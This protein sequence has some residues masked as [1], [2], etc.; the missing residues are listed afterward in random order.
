MASSKPRPKVRIVAKIRGFTDREFE[1][2]SGD[3]APWI[4][5]RKPGDNN[6]SEKVK[7]CFGDQPTRDVYEVDYC[8][9]QNE[10]SSIIFE[11]EIKPLIS[12]VFDGQNITIIAF[13]ARGSGK[14]YTIQGTEENQGLATLAIAELLSVAEEIEKSVAISIYEVFQDRVYDLID[15][16]HPEVQVLEAHGKIKLKGLYQG[17]VKSAP[18]FHTLYSTVCNSSQ[19]KPKM[20]AELP[21]RSHKGLIIYALSK[22][23][24]SDTKLLGKINFVDLA[25]YEDI[26]RKSSEGL[27][28]AESSKIN[29]SL[30]AL[31]NVVYALNANETHVPYRESKLTRMLQDSFGGTN[32][33]LMLTC[34]HPLFCQDTIYAASLA[35][36]SCQGV[37]RAL[38]N[39]SKSKGSARPMLIPSS[40]KGKLGTASATMNKSTSSRAYLSGKNTKS[41]VTGRKLF[42]EESHLSTPKQKTSV[43]DALSSIVHKDEEK[44]I[45]TFSAKETTEKKTSVSDA[46]STIVINMSKLITL[47][48]HCIR[49]LFTCISVC[50]AFQDE[51][52]CTDKHHFQDTNVD[53]NIKTSTY[54][55]YGDNME[56]ENRNLLVTDNGSPPISARLREIS[57]S[58]KSLCSSTPLSVKLPLEKETTSCQVFSA[59][60]AE[61]QTPVIQQALTVKDQWEVEKY[62]TPSE[63]FSARSS[64]LKVNL[65]ALLPN[66]VL[67]M[68]LL[69]YYGDKFIFL[70]HALVQD[71]L[72]F[73]NT[74]GK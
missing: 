56:K 52:L 10:D 55:E 68:T 53:S 21:R 30:Y 63:A 47:C 8:Y 3:S 48:F 49:I 44:S 58:L 59:D 6:S 22:N 11:R 16:A 35:S 23:G 74:A 26:R 69:S 17:F 51:S 70:Q 54:L 18:E 37:N 15:P 72:K 7:I 57:N 60:V 9:A 31:Q 73:L 13:G 71:Y 46:L 36:R 1:S 12:R 39:S 62:N 40:T 5:V 29:K 67:F 45:S 2:V 25:G 43:S 65:S 50:L 66:L 20:P 19:A 61:P 4:R 34:L 41:V 14:T 64:G 27:N 28:L 32:Y 38:T 33:A 42:E 24:S